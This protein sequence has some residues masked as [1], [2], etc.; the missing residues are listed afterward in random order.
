MDFS[1]LSDDALAALENDRQYV[2]A[3]L[4]ECFPDKHL[5][6]TEADLEILQEVLVSGPYTE[7]PEAELIALGTMLGDLFAQA[8]EEF[9]WVIFSDEE[10]STLAMRYAE[11]SIVIFPR[12]MIVKRVERGEEEIDL[13]VIYEGVVQAVRE[14]VESGEYS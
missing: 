1:P 4:E 8:I 7:D 5:I 2:P 3:V 13:Q 10:G 11:T 14:M 6:G 12:D 9:E